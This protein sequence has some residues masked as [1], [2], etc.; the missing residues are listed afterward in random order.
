MDLRTTAAKKCCIICGTDRTKNQRND[1]R[2]NEAKYKY[3]K[4]QR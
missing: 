3:K 1:S 4:R 2:P